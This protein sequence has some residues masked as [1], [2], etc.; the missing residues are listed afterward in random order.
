MNKV[1][2]PM[3]AVHLW[4]AAGLTLGQAGPTTTTDDG[5]LAVEGLKRSAAE[6][7]LSSNAP[8]RA[9]R[10][11]AHCRFVRTLRPK[12]AETLR[13]FGTIIYPSQQR[14]EAAIE[15]LEAYLAVHRDD[16]AV[17]LRWLDMTVA[18]RNTA[19]ERL[20]HLAK[21]SAD[22]AI[23]PTLRSEAEA[24]R[25][26]VFLGQGQ[27]PQAKEAFDRALQLDGGNASALVGRLGMIAEPTC[28]D[29]AAVLLADLKANAG[30][31][32]T[33]NELA[34]LLQIVGLHKQAVTYYKHLHVLADRPGSTKADRHIAAVRYCNAMLDAGMAVEV[35]KTI[36]PLLT[37]FTGSVD[38]RSI[39]ADAWTDR[40]EEARAKKQIAAI[41]SIY[42]AD[43]IGAK[44]STAVAGERAMF[45]IITRPDAERA[46]EYAKQ[47]AREAPDDI[48][49]IRLLGAAEIAKA[50]ADTETD[51]EKTDDKK[52]D[53]KD[54][55][56]LAKQG[57][58]RLESIADKDLYAAAL[59]AKYHIKTQKLDK[60]ADV[61][62]SAM[63]LP[64]GGPAFRLLAA[65][66]V[67]LTK[68]DPQYARLLTPAAE[69]GKIATLI[70]A[71]DTAC[72]A[73]AID[74][75][76]FVT[77][78]L[79]SVDGT[80]LAPGQDLALAVTLTNVST[81]PVPLGRRGLLEPIVALNVTAK[82]TGKG[83]GRKYD[84]LPPT[85][86][87]APRYLQPGKKLRTVV[88]LDVDLFG[89]LL[90]T[91]PLT[92]YALT[93]TAT[94]APAKPFG[95][96]MT[97]IPA[98]KVE[99]LKIVRTDVLGTFDRAK[100]DLWPAQYT[101]ALGAIGAGLKHADPKRRVVAARQVASLL[102]LV[103]A[104]E[105]LSAR[106]PK[107]LTGLLKKPPLLLLL[108]QALN[109]PSYAVRAETIAA[110]ANVSLDRHIRPMVAASANDSHPLVRF[111]VAELLGVSRAVGVTTTMRAL[112]A[113]K[114]DL[115]A[116]MAKA[117]GVR[118]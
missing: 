110:M 91:T 2:L 65:A 28:A 111:R 45:F 13:A 86:W 95:R 46:L 21:L 102:A 52:T 56:G 25:G 29:R 63:K 44:V 116:A 88:H 24:Q 36:E 18:A 83:R 27:A 114:N 47:V 6:L 22:A 84:N 32:P 38:L 67:D 51:D 100:A 89:R 17:A 70:S 14:H 68:A 4:W 82:A 16:H 8:R 101:K 42:G 72:L 1:I 35:T 34:D 108:R 99:P 105:R 76:K 112:A 77:V 92:E 58:L 61:I 81:V 87:P 50:L 19:E 54:E 49:A 94:V 106:A 59:L 107:P 37:T 20:T 71:A 118:R 90:A 31:A 3:L 85:V 113:D 115:V 41:A 80:T 9:A 73:M 23:L 104:I 109:D 33:A 40:G 98:L 75:N 5:D 60:A 10:L 103:R 57:R 97:S 30:Q 117:F 26:H 39:L 43:H 74:P 79:E 7:L 53:A 64:R 15:A 62:R 48:V 12:D 69:S 96:V 55:P 78:T 93:V 66:A 11:V